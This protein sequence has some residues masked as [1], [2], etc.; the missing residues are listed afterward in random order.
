MDIKEDIIKAIHQNPFYDWKEKELWL[1]HIEQLEENQLPEVLE[2]FHTLHDR[3]DNIPSSNEKVQNSLLEVLGKLH[4]KEEVQQLIHTVS[5]DD[6]EFTDEEWDQY[7]EEVKNNPEKMVHFFATLGPDG[8]EGIAEIIFEA[9]MNKE[10]DM[11]LSQFTKTMAAI[12]G[13]KQMIEKA[14]RE[15]IAEMRTIYLQEL[16]RK[17]IEEESSLDRAEEIIRNFRNNY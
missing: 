16:E 2:H 17:M 11:P 15:Y 12:T 5:D 7:M 9:Y 3:A 4:G 8:L 10:T 13:L 1:K 6:Q 14:N